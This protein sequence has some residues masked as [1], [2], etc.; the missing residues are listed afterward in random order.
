M[1]KIT[2]A[3][4]SLHALGSSGRVGTLPTSSRKA[5]QTCESCIN[6][7]WKCE[8][9]GNESPVTRK[10]SAG[11]ECQLVTLRCLD[12]LSKTNF[13]D[14][15]IDSPEFLSEISA[16]R[17]NTSRRHCSTR[18]AVTHYFSTFCCLSLSYSSSLKPIGRI[19]SVL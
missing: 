5:P 11:M 6:D 3:N 9:N 15:P 4:D 19:L 7:K 1:K 10:S 18:P 13:N 12:K 14:R 2:N 16:A 17:T 8:T